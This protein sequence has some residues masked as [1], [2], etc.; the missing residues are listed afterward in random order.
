MYIDLHL[1]DYSCLNNENLIF[2]A[3]FFKWELNHSKRTD[4]WT[5]MMEV[6]IAFHNFTNAPNFL[7][8]ELQPIVV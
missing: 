3:D 2:A 6:R 4:R 1:K 8:L 5:Y 7:L